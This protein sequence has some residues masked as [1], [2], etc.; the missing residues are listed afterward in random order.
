MLNWSKQFKNA[1]VTISYRGHI[2]SQPLFDG[3][4]YSSR[5]QTQV[6]VSVRGQR[7]KRNNNAEECS[8]PKSLLASIFKQEVYIN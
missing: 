5:T 8:F 2:Q 3:F 1:C 4:S 7:Q 6:D